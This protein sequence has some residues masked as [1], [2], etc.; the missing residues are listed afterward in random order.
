MKWWPLFILLFL[1]WGGIV[2]LGAEE[3]N[4]PVTEPLPYEEIEFPEWAHD[5]RRFEVI[6]FGSVPLSYIVTN[7]VYDLSI[8]ASHDFKTEYRMGT[9]RDQDDI[10]FMLI[11]SVSVSAGIAVLDYII[12]QVKDRWGTDRKIRDTPESGKQ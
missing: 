2:C 11:T 9:A 5:M 7:L 6:F 3:F 10:E 4:G 12:G 8:Y 1:Q